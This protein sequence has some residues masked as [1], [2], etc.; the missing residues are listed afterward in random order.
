MVLTSQAGES[1]D[2]T[3]REKRCPQDIATKATVIGTFGPSIQ[4]YERSLVSGNSRS[5]IVTVWRR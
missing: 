5:E 3:E 1:I 2:V 4:A